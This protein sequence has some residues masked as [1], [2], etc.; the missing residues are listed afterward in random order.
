MDHSDC[1]PSNSPGEFDSPK[2][3]VVSAMVWLLDM[4]EAGVTAGRS[5][6]PPHALPFLV[7]CRESI[8]SCQDD[9]RQCASSLHALGAQLQSS[10]TKEVGHT[11]VPEVE[12]VYQ[13]VL[14]I[15]EASPG[16][17]IEVAESLLGLAQYYRVHG[18]YESAIKYFQRLVRVMS[19]HVGYS[20]PSVAAAFNSL[21]ESQ[22][23][24]NHFGDAE[25]A[26]KRAIIIASAALGEEHD[27]TRGYRRNLE[28]VRAMKKRHE[29]P[30]RATKS[31]GSDRWRSAVAAVQNM[32]APA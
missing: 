1:R 29:M 27:H 30:S 11:R 7:K 9:V 26:C 31:V 19:C 10:C 16:S 22:A 25:Y 4:L 6:L 21:A 14:R 24:A 13:L 20:H 8:A 23:Q 17:E 15:R 5:K 18:C 3:A 2:A 32:A 12:L 28:A